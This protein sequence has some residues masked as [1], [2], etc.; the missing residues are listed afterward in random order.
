MKRFLAAAVLAMVVAACASDPKPTPP[1]GAPP[2]VV[3]LRTD[4]ASYRPGDK[5][6]VTLSNGSQGR[7]GYNLCFAFLSLE[8]ND[9]GTWKAAQAQLGPPNMGCTTELR[10]LRPGGTDS[11]EITI[12]AGLAAG[13]YRVTHNIEVAG[14]QVRVFSEAFAV[15][16]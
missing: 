15:A 6:I 14:S 4:A 10:L 3:S 5:A 11:S 13:N 8:R 9:G 2:G 7:V 16:A 12:P 1:S